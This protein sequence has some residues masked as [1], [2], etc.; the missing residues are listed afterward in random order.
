[1]QKYETHD[2]SSDSFVSLLLLYLQY[3]NGALFPVQKLSLPLRYDHVV[4]EATADFTI[5]NIFSD[6]RMVI[7]IDRNPINDLTK[8]EPQLIADAIAIHQK[9]IEI[10]NQKKFRMN[11]VDKKQK[12]D[13][14]E[15]G[16]PPE[17][18]F[19]VR[20]HGFW[21]HFYC[22]T[23]SASIENAM[24]TSSSALKPTSMFRLGSGYGYCFM[25]QRDRD[26]IISILD[27]MRTVVAASGRT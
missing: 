14:D 9:N 24:R 12:S 15:T 1:M 8:T 25:I 18:L 16:I 22:L 3:Y 2:A 6:Y 4:K 11:H 20:I 27:N 21:F 19:G 10:P 17:P 13:E 23:V 7:I 5:L 26:I